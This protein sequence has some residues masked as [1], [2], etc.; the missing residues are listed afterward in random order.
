MPISATGTSATEAGF[1]LLEVLVT[2]V[3]IGIVTTFAVMQIPGDPAATRVA[4]AGRRLQQFITRQRDEATLAGRSRG[5]RCDRRVCRA[6]E[7][8][9]R[10]WK[11]LASNHS[12]CRVPPGI[13]T[14]LLVDGQ[15]IAP[16]A[17]GP[18]QIVL[19]ASGETSAFQLTVS[20]AAARYRVTGDVAGHVTLAVAP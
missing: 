18:P 20:A 1:T 5:I 3:L 10:Q 15:T 8:Q 19:A 2:L 6:L 7:L 16:A 4:D 9:G 14:Q 17:T 13:R 11:P 12:R